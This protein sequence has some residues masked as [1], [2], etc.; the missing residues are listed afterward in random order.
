VLGVEYGDQITLL[1]AVVPDRRIELPGFIHL[2]LLWRADAEKPDDIVV[3][4]DL[5]D[6]DGRVA[7][8][9]VT[10]P[11]DGTF[12]SSAWSKGE[13]V[14]DQYS[15]WLDK[16]FRAGTYALRVGLDEADDWISLGTIEV[17]AP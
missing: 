10:V 13:V 7:D 12:P 8:Q 4:V 1:G 15:F 11:V 3:R 6:A 5:V 17:Q 16:G 9:I 14:R 2:A